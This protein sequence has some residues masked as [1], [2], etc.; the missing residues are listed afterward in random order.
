MASREKV[1]IWFSQWALKF[2][3]H[4]EPL[5]AEEKEWWTDSLGS[6]IWIFKYGFETD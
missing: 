5:G 1:M 3:F 4:S 2:I 6:A